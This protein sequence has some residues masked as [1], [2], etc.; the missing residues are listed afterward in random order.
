[1]GRTLDVLID[2]PG[3]RGQAPL[4]R[5]DLCR[6]PRRRRRDLGRSGT[7]LEPGDLVACEI[8]AAEGYDL[9]AQAPSAAPPERRKARPR[10]RRKP[11]ASSLVILDDV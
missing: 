1:M 6:R 3:A 9:V 2:A 11:A 7:H 4:A 5:P 8:V 10:P